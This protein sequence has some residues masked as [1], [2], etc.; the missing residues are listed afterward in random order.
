MSITF[1]F[2]ILIIFEVK[3]CDID[4]IHNIVQSSLLFTSKIFSSSQAEISIP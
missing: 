3:Y 4:Y 2:D 1:K